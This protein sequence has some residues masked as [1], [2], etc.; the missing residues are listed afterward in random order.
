MKI[1]AGIVGLFL[2]A[3]LVFSAIT[4][5]NLQKQVGDLEAKV[6]T[7]SEARPAQTQAPVASPT[8]DSS[9]PVADTSDP[10]GPIG[11]ETVSGDSGIAS[12]KP[13]DPAGTATAGG[14]VDL[15]NSANWSEIEKAAFEKEVLAVLAKREAEQEARRDARQQEWMTNRL[16]ERLGLSEQQAREI[17]KIV[18]TT[19]TQVRAL[20]DTMTDENRD[21]VRTQIQQ[22]MSAADTQVKSYLTAEQVATY[23][24]M[25]TQG[26]G[27]FG[28]FGGGGDG[29]RRRGGPGGGGM[30]PS[31][32][33]K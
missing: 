21:Q 16:K 8:G 32:D 5:Q 12:R 24:E 33:G 9:D 28:G 6:T 26:G 22:T 30:Q 2:T 7:L 14:P 11:T 15:S 19:S 29:G 31:G 3:G 4:I 27:I 10:S 25:K 23:D 20:R 1:A 17:G 13:S 18:E